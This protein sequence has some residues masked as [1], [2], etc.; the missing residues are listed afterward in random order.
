MAWVY[1]TADNSTEKICVNMNNVLAI[2]VSGNGSSLTP[3][4]QAMPDICVKENLSEIMLKM[5]EAL[6]E[7]LRGIEKNVPVPNT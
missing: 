1:L 4:D 5:R 2:K 3:I 7:G 6:G